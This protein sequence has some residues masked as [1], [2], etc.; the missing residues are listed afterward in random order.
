MRLWSLHPRYLDRKGL[1]ALWREA[2]LAKNVLEGKTRG[3]KNHPQLHRFREPDYPTDSINQYLVSIYEESLSRGYKF[4]RKK[5]DSFSHH[6][7]LTVTDKQIE[8]ELQHLLRKLKVRDKAG[9][10]LLS[11]QKDIVPHPLFRVIGGDI[12]KWEIL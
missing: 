10:E 6:C 8:Y 4:N 5:I 2:L 3:Y 11:S 9:Y 1:V 12:E 7:F